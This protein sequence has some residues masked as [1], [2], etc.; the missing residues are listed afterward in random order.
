M[1]EK[2]KLT[3][4]VWGGSGVVLD[5]VDG[6]KVTRLLTTSVPSVTVLFGYS[7]EFLFFFFFFFSGKGFFFLPL[8][9]LELLF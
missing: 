6:T 5:H 4:R 7:I 8:A 3:I 9:F 2:N 1:N